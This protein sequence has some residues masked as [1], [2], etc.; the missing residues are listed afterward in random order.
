[1]DRPVEYTKTSLDNY[2]QSM[3]DQSGCGGYLSLKVA[4]P[5]SLINAL[6]MKRSGSVV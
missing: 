3:M 1:M 4:A 6:L 2:L 5:N